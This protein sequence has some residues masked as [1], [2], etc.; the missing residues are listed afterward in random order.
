M[1]FDELLIQ[2]TLGH[3]KSY[4]FGDLQP[5]VDYLNNQGEL[6]F[7]QDS[8]QHTSRG[9]GVGSW[10]IKSCLVFS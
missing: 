4:Y 8:G 10:K 2:R 6:H 5:K 9:W 1:I 7:F 3:M